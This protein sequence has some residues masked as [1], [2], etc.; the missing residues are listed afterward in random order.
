MKTMPDAS[1]LSR[2]RGGNAGGFY[3]EGNDFNPNTGG[4]S[5]SLPV[6]RWDPTTNEVEQVTR[7]F[8]GGRVII[9]RD[10]SPASLGREI[11]PFP[12]LDAWL[13]LPDGRLALIRRDPFRIDFVSAKGVI[14]KGPTIPTTAVTVTARDRD[15]Y[16]ERNTPGRITAGLAGGGSGPQRA[17]SQWADEHFPKTL[18]PFVAADLIG[19]PEGEI[20]IPLSFT[21]ADKTRKY[22]IH[23]SAG[24]H[25]ANAVLDTYSRVVGFGAKSVYVARVSP[26][27]DLV[28]LAKY[29]R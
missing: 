13:P 20:W 10:G 11:T 22:A 8:G 7:V 16:R 14:T 25:I 27:D 6:V 18:P 29:A 15:W 23:D 12:H 3:F 9:R 5:D 21:S 19:T 2:V 17:G 26:D 28:Y 4:F 24:K 1:S